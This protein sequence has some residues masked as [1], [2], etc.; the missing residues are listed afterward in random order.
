MTHTKIFLRVR[1]IAIIFAALAFAAALLAPISA[2]AAGI[3]VAPTYGNFDTTFSIYAN[4]FQRNE[5]V[6]TW[7]GLPNLSAVSTGTVRA[8]D[9]GVV[10]FSFKPKTTQGGGE[11]IAVANGRVSGQV[12]VK[13]NVIAPPSD[14]KPN[15]NPTP[16]PVVIVPVSERTVQF[17]G[18]NYQS[19]ELVNTWY[20]APN[21]TVLGY[22]DFTADAWGN[23]A[24]NFTLDRS[25]MYG[26]YQLVGRGTRSG[27]TNYIT[28]SFFG[29]VSDVR[30][31]NPITKPAP[32]FDFW[33]GGFT[34]G[35]Q[36]SV[37]VGLPNGL[38]QASAIVNAT[39]GGNVYYRVHIP[40][41]WQYGG[42]VVAAYG[43]N[44]HVTKWQRFSY[45]DGH[46]ER[47]YP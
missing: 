5:I 34:P 16:K 35:E 21:G 22:R 1:H 39:N 20:R 9:S 19:G 43:W 27:Q 7:V 29:T 31:S 28:F 24:F 26:G 14:P 37:W 13:F 30:A 17:S 4:G 25:W 45:F 42:Y 32:Y 12:S 8:N 36:V 40:P 10:Q 44:S 18:K 15:P 23:L 3:S 6:D 33:Q 2:A 38:T 47:L 46:V 41:S 11:Y